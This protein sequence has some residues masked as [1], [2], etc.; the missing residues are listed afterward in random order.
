V[1]EERKSDPVRY[2]VLHRAAVEV[3]DV[4]YAQRIITVIAVPYDQPAMVEYRGELWEESFDRHAFDGIEKRPN[5]VRVNRQHDRSRTVGKAI[6]FHPSHEAGLLAELRI[7]QTPLGDE[8]LQL[9]D[10]DMLSASVGYAARPSDVVHD[11]RKM[12][13]RV[14]RAFLDHIAMT[15]NPAFPGAD[16]VDVRESGEIAV[17]QKRLDTP[18]LDEFLNDEILAWAAAKLRGR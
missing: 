12:T 4:Q 17:P 9:A 13:R 15:E 3:A 16:V 5:R 10:E 18:A 14:N 7:A 8:T 2:P 6:A 1:S 11:R